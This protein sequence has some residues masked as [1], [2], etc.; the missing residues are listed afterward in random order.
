MTENRLK[1]APLPLRL[2]IGGSFLAAGLTKLLPPGGPGYQ[3]IVQ[4]LAAF[5]VPAPQV[6]GVFVGFLETG[7][8]LALIAGLFIRFIA[9]T[10]V[11]GMAGLIFTGIVRGG[12]PEALPGLRMFP[13][14]LPG[15]Y[16]SLMTIAGLISLLISGAGI[17]SADEAL[18]ARRS[19]KGKT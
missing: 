4:E 16:I 1:W 8:G 15:Y 13:Y 14:Q 18:A 6:M 9:V 17:Y 19:A 5:G 7:V 3:N 2:F 11:L 12:L 10:N